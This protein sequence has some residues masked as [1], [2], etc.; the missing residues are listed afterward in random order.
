MLKRLLDYQGYLTWSQNQYKDWCVQKSQFDMLVATPSRLGPAPNEG[1]A[2]ASY[3]ADAGRTWEHSITG[4]RAFFQ[5]DCKVMVWVNGRFEYSKLE[6]TEALDVLENPYNLIEI[7]R[8][9]V[10]K[11]EARVGNNVE[12]YITVSGTAC[13]F[14]YQCPG[15]ARWLVDHIED[16]YAW[17]AESAPAH[18]KHGAEP[19]GG[20]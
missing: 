6:T 10:D 9:H 8:R 17:R 14:E 15:S 12:R 5:E 16:Y 1:E 7:S 19:V 4:G 11:I 13:T 3:P 20:S 2:S 18:T